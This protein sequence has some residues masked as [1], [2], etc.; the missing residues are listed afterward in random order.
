MLETRSYKR[1]GA[2]ELRSTESGATMIVG[3]GAVFRSY[4]QNLGGFVEQIEPGAFDDVLG[5]DVVA[6]VNHDPNLLLARSGAGTLRLSVDDVAFRYEIDLDMSDPDAVSIAAKI[7][8]GAMPG[9]SFSFMLADGGDTWSLTEQGFPLRTISRFARVIDTGPVTH[10]AYLGTTG[11]G[12]AT[13]LRSLS[14][15]TGAPIP[16]LVKA[17]AAG[18]LRSFLP[19]ANG[20]PSTS[21]VDFHAYRQRA[22]ALA[23]RA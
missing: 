3:A 17:A 8:S 1:V 22:L 2:P 14:A 11:D 10:P 13:A 7:R 4:S 20:Q 9:S 6:L 12:A 16:E 5:D 19:V 15:F 21:P 23:A 18:E